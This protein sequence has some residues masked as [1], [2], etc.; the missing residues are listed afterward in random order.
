LAG[1]TGLAVHSRLLLGDIGRTEVRRLT[2]RT[3]IDML[4]EAAQS[5]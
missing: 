2:A 3:G 4:G 5:L 1:R